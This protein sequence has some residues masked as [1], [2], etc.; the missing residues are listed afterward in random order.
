LARRSHDVDIVVRRLREL[1]VRSCHSFATYIADIEKDPARARQLVASNPSRFLGVAVANKQD[2]LRAEK[3]LDAPPPLMR[4]VVV[5]IAT[6][7]AEIAD[8]QFTI[9]SESDAAFNREAAQS[10]AVQI[11]EKIKHEN[12]GKLGLLQS[13]ADLADASSR[14][15]TFT[16]EWGHGRLAE[17]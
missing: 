4:P 7:T 11:D 6:D 17:S 15:R 1:G 3:L 16:Q 10:L 9:S 8:M 13:R 5:S 12:S 14:L 2:L